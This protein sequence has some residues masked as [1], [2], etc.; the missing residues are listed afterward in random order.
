VE[1]IP[2]GHPDDLGARRG[3]SAVLRGG[4][5]DRRHE[6]GVIDGG[7]P[8]PD[9]T[10]CCLV[11]EIGEELLQAAAGH[12]AVQRQGAAAT[13]DAREG[14]VERDARPDEGPLPQTVL[15]RVEERHRPYQVRRELR[16]QQVPLG[17]RL[18]DQMEVEHLE[19]SQAAVDQFARAARGAAGPVLGLHNADLE[20]SG[21]GVEGDTCA[22]DTT[23][24][25]QD[26]E[27]VARGG[28]RLERVESR[29][30]R[31]GRECCRLHR[32]S[33]LSVTAL[34]SRVTSRPRLHRRGV[35]K[36]TCLHCM[37]DEQMRKPDARM[38]TNPL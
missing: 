11:L 15:E 7:V 34:G 29:G 21:H 8:V 19:V 17:E 14:V 30:P 23:A 38:C 3:G 18:A 35:G 37:G 32:L 24:D 2:T 31:L 16:E 20:A 25:D 4:S 12:M 6:T 26:I 28:A 36:A 5:N 13:I 10:D 1:D 9:G 33:S 27:L 22:R